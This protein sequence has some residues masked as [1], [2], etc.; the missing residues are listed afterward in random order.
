MKGGGGSSTFACGV[1]VAACLAFSL[2][3]VPAHLLPLVPRLLFAAPRA[4]RVGTSVFIDALAAGGESW[5]GATTLVVIEST[6]VESWPDAVTLV[7][8]ESTGVES[9]PDAV[10]LDVMGAIAG[11]WGESWLV[12]TTTGV[13]SGEG[14]LIALLS[15]SWSSDGLKCWMRLATLEVCPGL[16]GGLAGGGCGGVRSAFTPT[17]VHILV[18][19]MNVFMPSTLTL[20]TRQQNRKLQS[21]WSFLQCFF[22][23]L[24]VLKLRTP[25][26]F[27]HG[28][29]APGISGKST[30][31]GD[32]SNTGGPGMV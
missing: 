18:C 23:S 4:G 30:N 26:H 15:G 2:L 22:R 32:G 12:A 6:G 27:L 14:D 20:Q 10:T 11:T 13:D 8:I 17:C 29:F 19:A 9:W 7:V 21:G 25:W 16:S 28:Y 1:I 5:S 31:T 24:C 3:R